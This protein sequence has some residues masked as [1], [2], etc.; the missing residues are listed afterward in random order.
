VRRRADLDAAV[1][2]GLEAFGHIDVVVANAGII[3]FHR[4]SLDISEEIYDLIVD[5]NLRGVWN[6][7]QATA[8][9]MI[10]AQ[11]GGSMIFTSSAAGLRGQVPYAHYV[12][13]KHGVVGLMKAFSNELARY[14]IRV[15]TV[16]PTGV[17]S[18]GMGND[19]GVG[20]VFAV[21][22]LFVLGASNTMPDLDAAFDPD[23]P[24]VPAISEREI[25]NAVLWLASDESR[26][27]TGVALPVDAG[28]TNKP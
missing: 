10:E 28:N 8:P 23:A 24:P 5:T 1:A 11:R 21:E 20:E 26:Y 6:T 13:S 25:A 4:S 3:T 17:S 16:H 14:R 9:S 2:A 22:P 15:N 19:A 12:A 27:V 7:V 18:P